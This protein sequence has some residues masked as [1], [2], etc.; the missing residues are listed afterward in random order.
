MKILLNSDNYYNTIN[1][2]YKNKYEYISENYINEFIQ[3]VM[4]YIPQEYI[5]Q[6]NGL[7]HSSFISSVKNKGLYSPQFHKYRSNYNYLVNNKILNYSSGQYLL[8][9]IKDE[10]LADLF[11]RSLSYFMIVKDKILIKYN[12]FIFIGYIDGNKIYNSE[13]MILC[14]SEDESQRFGF[15]SKTINE[16]LKLTN[17][18]DKNIQDIG[19][20]NNTNNLVIILNG[21]Y[22]INNESFLLKE[23]SIKQ[24]NSNENNVIKS[25]IKS[26]D[27]NH[28]A[29]NQINQNQNNQQ[30]YFENFTNNQQKNFGQDQIKPDNLQRKEIL[31]LLNIMIDMTKLKRKINYNLLI[32]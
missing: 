28:K 6:I 26:N 17:R 27:N 29:N 31:D 3:S 19:K 24:I 15:K 11:Q 8:K 22:S 5:K 12:L 1:K 2:K 25:N 20:Y 32:I 9:S 30:K 23:N 18:F 4:L 21:K 16:F 13:I 10:K 7:N 14:S